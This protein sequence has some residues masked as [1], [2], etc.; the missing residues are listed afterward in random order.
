[1]ILRLR[2][3]C[4]NAA[5]IA[6]CIAAAC[7]TFPNVRPELAVAVAYHESRFNPAATGRAGEAGLF[8]LLRVHDWSINGN[9]YAGVAHLSAVIRQA[10]GDERLGLATYNGGPGGARSARCQRYAAAVLAI[11]RGGEPE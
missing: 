1:M 4:P 9:T 11:A 6:E 8:Q 5:R 10:G 3:N 7:Q 2:P